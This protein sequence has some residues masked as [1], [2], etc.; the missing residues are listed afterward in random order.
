M[1]YFKILPYMGYFFSPCLT[2]KRRPNTLP[3]AL[4]ALLRTPLLQEV[5]QSMAGTT[6][7]IAVIIIFRKSHHNSV[8]RV[9]GVYRSSRKRNIL[10]FLDVPDNR[11]CMPR[12][13]TKYIKFEVSQH[14]W[15]EKNEMGWACGAYGWGEG[16]YRVLVWKPEGRRPLR[17][18][19]RRWVD[20]IRMDL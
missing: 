9:V 18:P 5:S 4:P 11:Q 14:R 7:T 12:N 20:N 2:D 13:W 8:E 19:R 10:Y 17:R 6:Q 1:I 15:I 16:V 3:Y